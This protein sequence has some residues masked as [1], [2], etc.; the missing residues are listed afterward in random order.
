MFTAS[1]APAAEDLRFTSLIAA[2][3]AMAC[4]ATPEPPLDNAMEPSE[5]FS[6]IRVERVVADRILSVDR[7]A[8]SH[9]TVRISAGSHR[10][11]FKTVH[12]SAGQNFI[13]HFQSLCEI[14]LQ[15]EPGRSY[16]FIHEP[17]ADHLEGEDLA[18]YRWTIYRPYPQLID[19]TSGLAQAGFQCAPDCNP[20]GRKGG[21]DLFVPCSNHRSRVYLQ[22]LCESNRP[23][24]AGRCFRFLLDEFIPVTL[25]SGEVIFFVPP[26]YV[27]KRDK[28]RVAAWEEC[29]L[30]KDLTQLEACLARHG[31]TRPPGGPP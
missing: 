13:P 23:R 17:T 20:V 4:A 6:I 26:T 9:P 24:D 18:G 10:I 21:R 5:G 8:Q 3:L 1:K 19:E 14:T 25:T 27:E 16:R 12:E 31:W 11:R 7:R 29:H 2:I 22:S 15:A 30:D 28:I